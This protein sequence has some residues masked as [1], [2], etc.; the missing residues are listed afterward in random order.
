MPISRKRFTLLIAVA[1]IALAAVSFIGFNFCSRQQESVRQLELVT[2]HEFKHNKYPEAFHHAQKVMELA[3]N[4]GDEDSFFEAAV[5]AAMVYDMMGKKEDCYK[6]IKSLPYRETKS[7]QGY[8]SQYYCRLMANYAAR[9]DNDIS[10]SIK[11]TKKAIELDWRLYP[12][13]TAYYYADL[14]NLAETYMLAGDTANAWKT[15]SQLESSKPLE[16][17]LYLTEVYYVHSQLAF[18]QG[19]YDTAYRYAQKAYELSVSYSAAYENALFVLGIMSKIDSIRGD[20]HG[21]MKHHLALDQARERIR[22]SEMAYQLAFL[23]GQNKLEIAKKDAERKQ[24]TLFF[25]IALMVLIIAVLGLFIYF[26]RKDSRN[27]EMMSMLEMQELDATLERE[28]MRN[29]L[30]KF[31]VERDQQQ[32]S[33]AQQDNASM[34][35]RLLEKEQDSEH[36]TESVKDLESVFCSQNMELIAKIEEQFPKLTNSEIRLIGFIKMGISSP[37]IAQAMNITLSSLNTSRYRLKKKMGLDS[38]TDL[39]AFIR[40]L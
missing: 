34:R 27:R 17:Q 7:P 3:R 39:N 22:G 15:V 37:T 12:K 38:K 35:L 9:I 20:D 11:W 32:L 23:E 8:A 28:K 13:D 1:V 6:L 21:S 26:L 4:E 2:R 25:S 19:D 24:L 10:R 40:S 5:Y 29:Q 18:D 33:Q 31:K 36:S 16:D 30:L 14:S